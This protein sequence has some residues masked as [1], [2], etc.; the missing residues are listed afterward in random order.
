[1]LALLASVTA[2]ASSGVEFTTGIDAT[3][4]EYQFHFVNMHPAGGR[5]GFQ[6]NA[7]GETGFNEAIDSASFGATHSEV[8]VSASLG[9]DSNS[10]L[11][12][13]YS[14]AGYQ[15]LSKYL[16]TD[17]DQAVSGVLTLYAP[18][19]TTYVKHFTVRSN[20]AG[21]DGNPYSF[22]LHVAGYINTTAAIDEIRFQMSGGNIDAG[23]I[24]MYGVG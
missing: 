1:M 12:S 9:Y 23:S 6:V 11:P 22:D 21:Y 16:G 4:N 5:L 15:Q 8:T 20:S 13:Q 18:S 17:N 24:H 2:S 3:Y 19:S 14:S 7:V 10:H